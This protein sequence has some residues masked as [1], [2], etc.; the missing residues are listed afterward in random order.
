M[1]T[2]NS[3]S[4]HTFR[5]IN[6][7]QLCFFNRLCTISRD[8]FLFIFPL[9]VTRKLILFPFNFL[10][11][12]FIIHTA[13]LGTA[14][15]MILL[16]LR[17]IWNQVMELRRWE[18]EAHFGRPQSQNHTDMSVRALHS[19]KLDCAPVIIMCS[20]V[21]FLAGWFKVK[22]RNWSQ[23]GPIALD[24]DAS[25]KGASITRLLKR[26]KSLF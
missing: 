6:R 2:E 25:W 18:P 14:R 8:G 24:D 11:V 26:P 5:T 22:S 19:A 12:L 17:G 9:P 16:S 7:C 13:C 15:E 1:V 10:E 4:H 3:S 20:L 21:N 23:N